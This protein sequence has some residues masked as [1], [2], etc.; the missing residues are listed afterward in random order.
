LNGGKATQFTPMS[1]AGPE[2]PAGLPWHM[3]TPGPRDVERIA[4]GT[5]QAEERQGR[6]RPDA[7]LGVFGVPEPPR[8]GVSGT[9]Y[10]GEDQ[11]P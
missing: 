2:H 1:E 3:C 10:Q 5:E 4:G 6:K 11:E 8:K 9:T 7:K